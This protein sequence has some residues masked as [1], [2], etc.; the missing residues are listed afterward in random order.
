MSGIEDLRV[1]LAHMQPELRPG[2]FV[3]CTL[4]EGKYGDH[5]ELEPIGSF[6]EEE[7]L[8]LVLAQEQADLAG[9]A[10][11]C[12]LRMISLKV[13]SSLTAVG[14][15]AA[16]SG[17]LARYGISANVLAGFYHDHIFVQEDR[18]DD[19]MEALAV[20]SADSTSRQ[21]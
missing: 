17:Q 20:L 5:A 6:Q 11:D 4:P 9:L 15:T 8:T 2:G 16:F 1:L 18:A 3:F 12:V 19:A 13:H 21:S 14:L 7:G 10:Y